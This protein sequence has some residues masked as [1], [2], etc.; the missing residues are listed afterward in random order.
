MI[1]LYPWTPLIA[2]LAAPLLAWLVF[3][4]RDTPRRAS[5]FVALALAVIVVVQVVAI[6][7]EQSLTASQVYDVARLGFVTFVAISAA[8][9]GGLLSYAVWA[10]LL[11]D[12]A[13]A[14]NRPRLIALTLILALALAL[15][16]ALAY[17]VA[18]GEWVS[19][20][21]YKLGVLGF[22]GSAIWQTLI[23]TTALIIALAFPA[24][25]SWASEQAGA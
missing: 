7:V 4:G 24:S 5:R 23:S 21:L 16:F 9:A 15:Q 13:R 17:R 11:A 22:I 10:L 14:G 18:P 19:I 8:A 25:T 6:I 20:A 2:G 1:G 12:A 3:I